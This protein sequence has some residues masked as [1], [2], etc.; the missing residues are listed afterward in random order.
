MLNIVWSLQNIK[1]NLHLRLKSET[2]VPKCYITNIYLTIMFATLICVDLGK[3]EKRNEIPSSFL[4]SL[5]E[6]SEQF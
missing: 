4:I 3:G 5:N 2:C 1:N 6:Q